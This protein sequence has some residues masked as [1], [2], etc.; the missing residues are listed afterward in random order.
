MSYGGSKRKLYL[1]V[2]NIIFIS[3]KKNEYSSNK[4]YLVLPDVSN[5]SYWPVVATQIPNQTTL[6]SS[7]S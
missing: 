1:G 3:P 6:I 7:F 5:D 2:H 4:T